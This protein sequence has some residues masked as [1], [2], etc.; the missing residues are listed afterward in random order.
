VWIDRAGWRVV[1]E[2]FLKEVLMTINRNVALVLS[3]V[4]VLALITVCGQQ[5]KDITFTTNSPEARSIFMEGLA[6]VG[7]S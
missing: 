1:Q 2:D 4:M 5:P 7:G 3:L 6:N